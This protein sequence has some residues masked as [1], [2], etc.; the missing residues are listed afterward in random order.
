MGTTG[1]NLLDAT[2]SLPLHFTHW[3]KAPT[4]ECADEDGCPS[5]KSISVNIMVQVPCALGWIS[6]SC[7]ASIDLILSRRNYSIT[8]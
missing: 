2:T 8:C 7:E 5:F 6:G 3:D 1:C 4:R